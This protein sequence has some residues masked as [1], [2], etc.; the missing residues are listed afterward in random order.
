MANDDSVAQMTEAILARLVTQWE[1][2]KK[3]DAAANDAV[4]ADE[5]VAFGPDGSC[6]SGKPTAQQMAE[7][8]ITGYKLSEFRAMPVGGDVALVTYFAEVKN[9]GT[10]VGFRMAVGEFWVKR[11]GQWFIRG[12]SGTQMK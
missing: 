10:D 1:A 6:R 3:R 8:P 2:W 7:E 12:F 11:G 4:I 5:F 9:P